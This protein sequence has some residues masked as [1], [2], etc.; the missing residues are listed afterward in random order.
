MCPFKNTGVKTACLGDEVLKLCQLICQ[1]VLLLSAQ[2]KFFLL[3]VCAILLAVFCPR[4]PWAVWHEIQSGVQNKSP[5][6]AIYLDKRRPRIRRRQCSLN[7]PSEYPATKRNQR[8]RHEMSL[9]YCIS[10]GFFCLIH[11]HKRE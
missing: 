6:R 4:F 1:C 10:K 5:N 2:V 8:Q 9:F 7:S 3:H 11:G